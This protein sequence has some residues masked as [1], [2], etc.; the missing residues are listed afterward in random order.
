MKQKCTCFCSGVSI[1]HC[2]ANFRTISTFLTPEQNRWLIILFQNKTEM[3]G[4]L[5][6]QV[7]TVVTQKYSKIPGFCLLMVGC[8]S[9]TYVMY[10]VRGLLGGPPVVVLKLFNTGATHEHLQLQSTVTVQKLSLMLYYYYYYV[11]TAQN[12]SYTLQ[13]VTL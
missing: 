5:A 4:S 3:Q 11:K 13:K 12:A 7:D 9:F 2:C 10:A 8:I 1:F 6:T